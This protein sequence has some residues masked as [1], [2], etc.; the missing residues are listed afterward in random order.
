MLKS[1]IWSG[2]T[3]LSALVFW[4][5]SVAAAS[6]FTASRVETYVESSKNGDRS[7]TSVS[8]MTK[9]AKLSPDLPFSA[10]RLPRT[11]VADPRAP[12]SLTLRYSEMDNSCSPDHSSSRFLSASLASVNLWKVSPD[13]TNVAAAPASSS[14][15]LRVPASLTS[16]PAGTGSSSPFRAFGV[17]GT[18]GGLYHVVTEPPQVLRPRVLLLR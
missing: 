14:D 9:A 8:F 1:G 12:L 7:I 10:K 18:T 5:S 6:A 2:K 16:M 15:L 17:D 11:M 13:S 4:T 3:F